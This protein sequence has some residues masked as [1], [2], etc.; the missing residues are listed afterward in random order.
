MHQIIFDVPN[1][2]LGRELLEDAA[3]IAVRRVTVL[4]PAHEVRN[5]GF[6]R[7]ALLPKLLA[8]RAEQFVQHERRRMQSR[9]RHREEQ[10]Q[11][12]HARSEAPDVT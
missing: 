2:C 3:V 12:H 4:Q 9:V 8:R 10:E 11:R 6:H 5:R 1:N 7:R